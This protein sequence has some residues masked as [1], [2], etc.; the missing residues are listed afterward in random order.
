M[1]FHGAHFYRPSFYRRRTRLLD[2][3]PQPL[4]I[5]W[6]TSHG[7]F[8]AARILYRRRACFYT[9]RFSRFTHLLVNVRYI[10]CTSNQ[11][12]TRRVFTNLVNTTVACV[13]IYYGPPG[14]G[15]K[16]YIVYVAP[17]LADYALRVA[18]IEIQHELRLGQRVHVTHRRPLRIF[19]RG[20]QRPSCVQPFHA[21]GRA[22][23]VTFVF[24]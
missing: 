4:Q 12:G 1:L 18:F 3:V 10:A 20:V 21:E 11:L 15:K 7:V 8:I 16:S 2:L 23:V 24:L 22:T 19:G 6:A 14:W 9:Y 17:F 5:S 13:V